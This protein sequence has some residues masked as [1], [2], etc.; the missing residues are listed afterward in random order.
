MGDDTLQIK[1]KIKIE[2]SNEG[3]GQ[4]SVRKKLLKIG[5]DGVSVQ[6][7]GCRQ[8]A[9][10]VVSEMIFNDCFPVCLCKTE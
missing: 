1:M 9:V 10:R 8:T 3:Q 6:V 7:S 4:R 5:E 2:G